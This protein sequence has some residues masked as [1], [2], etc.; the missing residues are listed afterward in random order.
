MK[1]SGFLG[2]ALAIF[3]YCEFEPS[4]RTKSNKSK[5][6]HVT[7]QDFATHGYY[8]E[9][10]TNVTFYTSSEANGTITGDGEFSQVSFGGFTFGL[11]LP[12]N[13]LTVDSHEYI[14]LIVSTKSEA[15]AM[16]C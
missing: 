15:F 6:I 10:N 14:G 1:T 3:L 13:A 7:A 8:T 4:F 2:G 5:A 12:P 11:A 16:K 9:P